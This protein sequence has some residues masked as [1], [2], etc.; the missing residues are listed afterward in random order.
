MT[1]EAYW[2]G[3]RDR[4]DGVI[5]FHGGGVMLGMITG[6]VKP[7]WLFLVEEVR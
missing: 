4:E 1:T 6:E 7:E 5:H 2:K 3:G